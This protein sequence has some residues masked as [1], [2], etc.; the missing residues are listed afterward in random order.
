MSAAAVVEPGAVTFRC[1]QSFDFRAFQKF[2]LPVAVLLLGLALLVQQL[3][4]LSR[5]DGR[6]HLAPVQVAVDVVF[7]D[8]IANQLQAF[9]RDVPHATRVV[10]TDLLN[11]LA[12]PAR[13][14]S[15][16]LAAAASGGAPANALAFEQH[17]TITALGEFQCRRATGNTATDDTN[18]SR[19]VT[20]QGRVL[21]RGGR[22]SRVIRE[23][24]SAVSRQSRSD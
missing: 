12:L 14:P 10:R 8:A 20:A 19:D 16:G 7:G 15:D 21:R 1:E 11:Q 4:T 3:V 5:L 18:V 23:C 2:E 22:G 13:E 17:D 6:M 9:E 24:L